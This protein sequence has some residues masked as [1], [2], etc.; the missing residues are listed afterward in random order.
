M[1][2]DTLYNWR[3]IERSIAFLVLL[4]LLLYTFGLLFIAPYPG[5]YF[6]PTDGRVIAIFVPRN[7]QPALSLGDTIQRVGSISLEQFVSDRNTHVFQG[8]RTGQTVEMEV[9][10]GDRTMRIIWT[11]A[12]FNQ[13]EFLGRFFNIWWLS[14]V[15]W[16]FGTI[17]HLHFRPKDTQWRLFVAS[18]FLMAIFLMIGSV[19]SYR[20]LMSAI[21]MRVTAWL[22]LPVYV[23]FH[24]IFPQ[25]FRRV[26]RWLKL[27]FYVM[28]LG[29]ALAEFFRLPPVSLYFLAVIGAFGGSILLLVLHFIFHRAHRSEILLLAGAAMLALFPIVIF[30]IVGTIGQV[31][32]SIGL[33][34]LSLP[35]LP[36]AYF[37]VLYRRSLGGLELRANRAISL[38]IFLVILGT[39]LMLIVAYSGEIQNLAKE[40][41]LFAAVLM[42]LLTTFIG[43][44]I[45]P[46]FQ[47]FVERRMLR[48]KMPAQNMVEHFSARI[49]TSTTSNQLLK[50]LEDEVF[51]SLFIRQY[52]F[53]HTMDASPRVMLFA[54]VEPAQVSEDGLRDF[55][56]SVPMG[57]LIPSPIGDPRFGWVR[58]VLPLRIGES[59]TGAWLLGRRDP[60]DYYPQAELPIL[61]SFA[62]QTAVALSYNIQTER[63]TKM[64]AA[65]IQRYEQERL[66]L[67]HEL[68][69]SLLNE[70]AAMLMKHEPDTLPKEFQDSFDGLIVRLRE[71]VRDLRPPMLNYGLK[72]A[73]NGLADN[74][75]ARTHDTV[76]V[77]SD[78]QVNDQVRYPEIVEHNVY[79]ILQE[80]C[81]NALKYARSQ[82]I[83]ITGELSTGCIDLQVT[84]DGVGFKDGISLQLDDMVANRHYGLAGMHERAALIGASIKIDSQ[85]SQGTR[86]QIRWEAKDTM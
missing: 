45:F 24:W 28:I 79:R 48:I 23:H 29:I 32:H 86:I 84:D 60:D 47:S 73:L 80:A 33:S 62:N 39:V 42:A 14:Y 54:G 19:S 59:L 38:Y 63:L 5:L 1:K 15:F 66:R 51:P 75:S 34:L 65:N 78:I 77:S 9:L 31:H 4:I 57:Q 10:R 21:F 17:A 30:S 6:N 40:A 81:E 52:A 58:L 76:Q 16:L 12:G 25:S 67:G 85:L 46:T 43:V 55:L 56:A 27:V 22:L 70:M 83:R 26:P 71:I 64:Y 20:I 72:Y 61:Q 18:N 74:L 82:S 53:V 44:Q 13:A 35:I 3:Q 49:V 8:M 7:A 2:Q 68:H 69:D 50:L 41:Y 37:Y 36:G 11:Y